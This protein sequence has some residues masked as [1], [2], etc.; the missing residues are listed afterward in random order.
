MTC[1][2]AQCGPG[3]MS[4]RRFLQNA[5]AAAAGVA[6]GGCAVRDIDADVMVATAPL[7]SPLKLYFPTMG[8]STPAVLPVKGTGRHKYYPLDC[9]ELRNAGVTWIYDWSVT[10]EICAGIESVPMI[11]SAGSVSKPIGGN[12]PWVLGF[13]EP[14][15]T[16]QSNI[17][18]QQAVPLWW[19]VEAANPDKLLVA[20]APA[21]LPWLVEWYDAFRTEYGRPPVLDAL[22]VHFYSSA[23]VGDAAGALH[24]TLRDYRAQ[25]NRWGVDQVWLTEF[26]HL[27][28]GAAF[29]EKVLPWLPDECDRYAWFQWEYVGNEPWAFGVEH[30]TSLWLDGA[31]TEAGE[32]YAR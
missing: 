14:D 27:T 22:A 23:S 16:S 20:P 7:E 13:N 29:L 5:T 31:L 4:R 11:Y 24:R 2:R 12:S 30:N 32:V 15:L 28:Q 18:P 19:Q 25:A 26:A 10:P 8:K 9:Q 6:V 21:N 17:T 1:E 3:R